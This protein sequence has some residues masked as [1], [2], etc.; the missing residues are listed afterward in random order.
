M[1][2]WPD[3]LLVEAL[4]IGKHRFGM[5]A[6]MHSQAKADNNHQDNQRNQQ[7]VEGEAAFVGSIGPHGSH[8]L[9]LSNAGRSNGVNRNAKRALLH[10]PPI[11]ADLTTPQWG[12]VST[13]TLGTLW[14]I[15]WD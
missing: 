13:K 4:E 8:W 10:P 14:G 1:G 12:P 6:V 9:E 15:A 5:A 3:S 2:A 11:A 7:L